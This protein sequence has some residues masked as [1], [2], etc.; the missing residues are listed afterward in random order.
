GFIEPGESAEEALRREVR[1][2]V[3]ID[4]RNREYLGSQN[5]P[6]PN[7]LML[8]FHAEYAGGEIVPQPREIE[9]THGW[10]VDQLPALPPRG[11]T[12]RWLIDCYLARLAGQPEPPVPAW[13]STRS[14]HAIPGTVGAD[15]LLRPASVVHHTASGLAPGVAAGLAQG[16]RP[17][18]TVG[19]VRW[20]RPAGLGVLPVSAHR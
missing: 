6:L 14:V 19:A 11:T 4:V 13:S 10:H 20:S 2:E 7:S 15:R 3:G 9:E 8:G 16:V 5:W 12:S 18:G 1:E 17:A